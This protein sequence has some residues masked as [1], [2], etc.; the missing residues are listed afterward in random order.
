MD[1][2]LDFYLRILKVIFLALA[3][4]AFGLVTFTLSPFKFPDSEVSNRDR[5]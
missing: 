1:M 4:M 5:I 2:I 3:G